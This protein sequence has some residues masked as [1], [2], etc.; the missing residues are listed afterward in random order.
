MTPKRSDEPYPPPGGPVVAPSSGDGRLTAFVDRCKQWCQTFAIGIRNRNSAGTLFSFVIHLILI[1]LLALLEFCGDRLGSGIVVKS[2]WEEGLEDGANFD[3]ATD[4]E[5]GEL[6]EEE[7]F[8]AESA[9]VELQSD[10]QPTD[11]DSATIV[12]TN[13]GGNLPASSIADQLI[14]TQAEAA[15]GPAGFRESNLTGRDPQGRL[16][17]ARAGGG[18]EASEAAV[19]EAIRW[20]IRHQSPDGGWSHNHVQPECGLQC[21]D[22]TH[23]TLDGMRASAT[24][25]A[26]LAILGAGYTHKEGPYRE[27]VRKALY[28]LMQIGQETEHGIRFTKPF[29]NDLMYEQ[30][31]ATLAL[32]EAYQMTGDADLRN[33]CQEAINFIRYAQSSDGGWGYLPKQSGDLSIGC[34]QIMAMK[35]AAAAGL[36][37]SIYSVKAFDKFLDSQQSEDKALYGYRSRT[38]RPSMSAIGMLVRMYR[39]MGN[40]NPTLLR[41]INYLLQIGP[42][43]N[44]PYFNFYASQVLFHQQGAGWV[45]WNERMRNMLIASQSKQ[46][47]S[48]GSWFEPEQ[49]SVVGGRIYCTALNCLT[50]EVY[51]RVLPMYQDSKPDEFR[52]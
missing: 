39:G 43:R 8:A 32:C 21:P 12:E 37:V 26:L 7:S 2:G 30:G 41:G 33:T 47:H 24:G 23:R 48:A 20:L 16:A 46:G 14:A 34:W 50:L 6:S 18:N 38:P 44:D 52:F 40:T 1:I 42:S 22:P 9:S 49:Y 45:T 4:V 3:I 31:I 25:L 10:W 28:F 36:E 27:E 13:P 51:Y 17:R 35:S 5:L 15:A 29:A 11:H 19:E